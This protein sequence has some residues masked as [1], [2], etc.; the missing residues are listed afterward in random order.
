M[1]FI[2]PLF[3]YNFGRTFFI[4]I[5]FFCVCR[6]CRLPISLEMKSLVFN[7]DRVNVG[8]IISHQGEARARNSFIFLLPPIL[9]TCKK[10]SR[11]VRGEIVSPRVVRNNVLGRHK[12]L[13]SHLTPSSSDMASLFQIISQIFRLYFRIIPHSCA[14]GKCRR[15]IWKNSLF[16]DALLFKHLVAWILFFFEHKV[17]ADFNNWCMK[18]VSIF[19]LLCI[20]WRGFV[21]RF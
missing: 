6:C 1:V 8:F 18:K 7:K 15:K 17:S 20:N 3:C 21:P 9:T 14:I 13:S 11:N 12:L 10:L 19:G 2:S 4:I 5:L 16:V